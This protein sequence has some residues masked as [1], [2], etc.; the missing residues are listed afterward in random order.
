[1]AGKSGGDFHQV[2]IAGEVLSAN[3]TAEKQFVYKFKNLIK[4]NN[5]KTQIFVEDLTIYFFNYISYST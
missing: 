4:E 5:L 2:V 1:M 3:E